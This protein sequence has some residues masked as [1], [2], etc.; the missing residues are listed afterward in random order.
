MAARDRYEHTIE[1]PHAPDDVWSLTTDLART[2]EW[3]TTI[4]SIRPP[5]EL[6]VGERFSGTTRLLGRSWQWTLQITAL[7]PTRRFAYTVVDGV[8][9][10]SV[11][12]TIE[13]SGRGCRFTMTGWIDDKNLA[14]RLLIP[15]ALPVLRREAARHLEQL[16]HLLDD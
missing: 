5:A 14:A 15:F 6:R 12:Y 4:T 1:L 8:A 16:R 11:E 13:P 3:R 2:P 9:R 10:P 7:E